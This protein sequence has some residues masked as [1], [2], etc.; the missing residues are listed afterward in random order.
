MQQCDPL[1]T[2]GFVTTLHPIVEHIREEVPSLALNA[3]YLDDGTL[4]GR[5]EDLAAALDIVGH[6]GPPLS[7]Y[8]NRYKSLLYIPGHCN[9]SQ[10]SLPGDIPVTR[11]VFCI[12]GYPAG[13][14]SCE[15]V[16]QA[17]IDKIK[18]SLSVLH[19]V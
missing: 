4:A 12:L 5:P 2:L 16:L 11:E 15:N 18:E 17:S 13:P 9:A 7:L 3:W 19:N 14:P 10:S 6:D 1:G 8:L